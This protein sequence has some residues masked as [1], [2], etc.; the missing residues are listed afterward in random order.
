M[1]D[2][3]FGID[4]SGA[5]TGADEFIREVQR[6]AAASK[7]FQAAAGGT[8]GAAFGPSRESLRLVTDH[9]KAV[10]AQARAQEAQAKA[11]VAAARAQE[12]QTQATQS[13]VKAEEALNRQRLAQI[14]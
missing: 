5:R 14:R 13:A 3:R 1:A 12:T 7:Q 2:V 10:Q 4:A 6:M 8:G 9:A 11:A